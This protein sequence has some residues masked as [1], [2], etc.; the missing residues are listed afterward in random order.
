MVGNKFVISRDKYVVNMSPQTR[1]ILLASTA[2]TARI[3]LCIASV[4]GFKINFTHPITG[5]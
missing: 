1:D 3:P 5:E 2:A 4:L